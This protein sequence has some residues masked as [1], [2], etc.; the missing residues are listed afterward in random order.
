MNDLI[1]SL[2]KVKGHSVSSLIT[3]AIPSHYC[4]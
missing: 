2:E 1:L 3:L 4:I